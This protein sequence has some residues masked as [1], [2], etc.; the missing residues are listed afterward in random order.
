MAECCP[1]KN[2]TAIFSNAIFVEKRTENFLVQYR[3]KFDTIPDFEK[4]NKSIVK[5]LGR[6]WVRVEIKNELYKLYITAARRDGF[7]L[8]AYSKYTKIND[9]LEAVAT[10]IT[11]NLINETSGKNVSYILTITGN[12]ADLVR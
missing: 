6:N 8:E 4:I 1:P 2:I 12:I 10:Q 3:Y 7:N 9:K 5:Y 11:V